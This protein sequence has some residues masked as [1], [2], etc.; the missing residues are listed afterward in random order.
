MPLLSPL[1][2]LSRGWPALIPVPVEGMASPHPRPCQG[3]G[4][5][6]SPSLLRRCPALIAVAVMGMASP[7]RCQGDGQIVEVIEVDQLGGTK[8]TGIYSS[9]CSS[10]FPHQF[11][12]I[13]FF[14]QILE[15]YI[16][17]TKHKYSRYVIEVDQLR[18]TKR[19][20]I[21]S[22]RCTNFFPKL[23]TGERIFVPRICCGK[24]QKKH[25]KVQKYIKF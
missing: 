23:A 9:R 10:F 19:T 14:S 17:V 6:S 16:P 18:G 11:F 24:R 20:G 7:H 3:D 25:L 4:Q 12:Q 21:Y 13:Q 8:P 22:S 5:P 15:D 1:P 2:S